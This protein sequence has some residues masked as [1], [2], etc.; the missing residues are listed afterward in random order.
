MAGIT[1]L[2]VFLSFVA[3]CITLVVG[4][5]VGHGETPLAN[6]LTWGIVTLILQFTAVC[7][8]VMHARAEKRY[9]RALEEALEVAATSG[10]TPGSR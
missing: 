3:G 6:H 9:V 7:I 8:S 4:Y 1:A 2:L 5:Q 10:E